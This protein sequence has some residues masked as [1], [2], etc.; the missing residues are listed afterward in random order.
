MDVVYSRTGEVAV[1]RGY[2]EGRSVVFGVFQYVG[3]HV[4][5]N[6]FYVGFLYKL[7]SVYICLKYRIEQQLLSYLAKGLWKNIYVFS[8]FRLSV[9]F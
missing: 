7:V 8:E 5:S 9:V 6:F 2:R 1:F 3:M 4:D